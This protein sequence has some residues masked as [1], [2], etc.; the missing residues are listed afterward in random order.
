MTSTLPAPAGGITFDIATAD[1]TAQDDNPA[2]EDNDYVAKSLTSQ[3]IP[4]TQTTYTFDVTINGYGKAVGLLIRLSVITLIVYGG[5]MGLT[6]L[7]F[8]V[9]PVGFI[10]EQDKGYLVLNAQLPDGATLDRSDEIIKQITEVARKDEAVDHTI[11]LQGYSVLVSTNISNV[12]GMFIILKPFEDRA[13]KAGVSEPMPQGPGYFEWTR[14]VQVDLPRVRE[15]AQAVYA[16]S[17]AYLASLSEADLDRTFDV[18]GVG[19]QT[20]GWIITQW[21][22]GHIHDETGEISAIKGVNGMTGYAE[23]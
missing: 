2:T 11:G 1:G 13:G 9:V 8:K 19:A 14:S 23:G 18:P 3:T 6:Y 15:Y 4:A 10:P 22:I 7:G 20:L 17:D 12:G 16:A 5:L 21:V